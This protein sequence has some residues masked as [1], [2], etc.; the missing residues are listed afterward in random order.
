MRKVTVSGGPLKGAC[1]GDLPEV[2][3]AKS[4]KSYRGDPRFMQYCRQF[5]ASKLIDGAEAPESKSDSSLNG[6]LENKWV[7]EWWIWF[8]SG[9]HR[10]I[11]RSSKFRLVFLLLVTLVVCSR[12]N[13]SVL[14]GK[15]TVLTVKTVFRR[16]VAL[17]T[18]VLDS[19]LDEAIQQVDS[20]LS[21]ASIAAQTLYNDQLPMDGQSN[22]FH[23]FMH[24]ICLVMGSILG[25]TYGQAPFAARNP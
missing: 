25:R 4:A 9:A 3:I 21:P 6:K 22:S 7:F 5:M 20:A 15:V 14:C 16:S 13:F 10:W 11:Q 1:Y 17:V 12:P 2:E 23:L 8:R 24:L 19:I 18:L